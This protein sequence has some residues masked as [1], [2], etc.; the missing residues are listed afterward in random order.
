MDFMKEVPS[1]NF[2]QMNDRLW[3]EAVFG[4]SRMSDTVN[5]LE[6]S[7]HPSGSAESLIGSVGFWGGLSVGY[8]FGG[9]VVG[10]AQYGQ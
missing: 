8:V 9:F 5:Q 2:P 7:L 1:A 4:D 6:N 10:L 3:P